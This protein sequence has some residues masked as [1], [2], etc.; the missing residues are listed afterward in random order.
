[1]MDA[2]LLFSS[3]QDITASAESTNYVDSGVVRNLGAGEKLSLVFVVTTAF[4]DGSSNSTVTPSLQ[5]DDNTS[6]GSPATVRT[7][8]VFAAL[9]AAKTTRVYDLSPFTAA[10]TYERYIRIYY[11]VANGDLSTGAFTTFLT[12][13]AQLFRVYASGFSIS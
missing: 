1:M 9:T 5:T 8:D 10:G 7:Y 6:F 13:D 11:T 3:A 12:M 4:T 2:Q